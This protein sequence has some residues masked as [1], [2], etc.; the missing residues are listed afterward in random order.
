MLIDPSS[1]KVLYL[2]Q[3]C[4]VTAKGDI[5]CMWMIDCIEL[6][7]NGCMLNGIIGHIVAKKAYTCI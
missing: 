6:F 1:D 3:T 4:Q 5:N 2:V 7:M